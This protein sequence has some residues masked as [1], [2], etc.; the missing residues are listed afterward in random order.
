MPRSTLPSRRFRRSPGALTRSLLKLAEVMSRNLAREWDPVDGIFTYLF[1]SI[2]DG[3][4][5][6]EEFYNRSFHGVGQRFRPLATLVAGTQQVESQSRESWEGSGGWYELF[7][8]DIGGPSGWMPP[9]QGW[10]GDSSVLS[11]AAPCQGGA[12]AHRFPPRPSLRFAR[13]F[14][15]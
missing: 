14:R 1:S 6:T 2:L 13:N 7:D 3:I 9:Y 5:E 10:S 15:N 12:A 4:L 8:G 11:S